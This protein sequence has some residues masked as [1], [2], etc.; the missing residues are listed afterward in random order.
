MVEAQ[1]PFLPSKQMILLG[2]PTIQL[3]KSGGKRE[4]GDSCETVGSIWEVQHCMTIMI[5]GVDIV[6]MVW[7]VFLSCLGE[8]GIK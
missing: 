8:V 7:P 4:V 5:K 1:C 6:G 2:S 3:K